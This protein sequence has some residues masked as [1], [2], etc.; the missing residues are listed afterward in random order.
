MADVALTLCPSRATV[1]TEKRRAWR[2]PAPGVK[3]VRTVNERAVNVHS[4]V[5]TKLSEASAALLRSTFRDLRA[6]IGPVE[7][8]L[9]SGS[10]VDVYLPRSITIR[11]VGPQNAECSFEAE[12]VR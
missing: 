8:P 9:P 5:Y 7:I 11:H 2:S 10:S 6:R 12:E 1:R 3:H 4:L